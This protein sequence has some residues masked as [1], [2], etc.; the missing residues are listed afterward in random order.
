M[1]MNKAN[2]CHVVVSKETKRKRNDEKEKKNI[3]IFRAEKKVKLFQRKIEQMSNAPHTNTEP[4]REREKEC[5]VKE[6]A[7]DWT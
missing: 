4:K 3:H 6:Q 1:K 2:N 7:F 5:I